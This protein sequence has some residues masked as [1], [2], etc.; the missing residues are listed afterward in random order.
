MSEVPVQSKVR[1]AHGADTD[2][3]PPGGVD[4]D[5]DPFADDLTSELAHAAPRTWVNR[6]T[7]AIGGLV[8]IVGGFVGGVQVQKHYGGSSA[9]SSA[10]QLAA[11]RRNAGSFFGRGGTGGRGDA[12]GGGFGGAPGTGA[13][14]AGGGTTTSAGSGAQTGTVKLID[15]STIYVSLPNGD[16]LTVKTTKSTKVSVATSSTVSA[17]KPGEAITVLGGAPDS[18][19]NVTATSVSATK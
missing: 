4:L 5:S 17:L 6:T 18:S 15:G 13:A 2:A 10:N 3:F 14:T 7:V 8:L 16:V 11:A 12:G 9:T 19:G 1:G